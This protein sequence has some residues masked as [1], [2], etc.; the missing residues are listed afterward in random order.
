MIKL[1]FSKKN[2]A[3]IKNI[4]KMFLILIKGISLID[5]LLNKINI[6]IDVRKL[7]IIFITHDILVLQWFSDDNVINKYVCNN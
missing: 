4:W 3:G 2:N 7:S 1:S 6:L 5:Y